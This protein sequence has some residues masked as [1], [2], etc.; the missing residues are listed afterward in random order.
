MHIFVYGTTH[1]C[2]PT[3]TLLT[4]YNRHNR[5]KMI[6]TELKRIRLRYFKV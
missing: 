5:T 1:Y 2:R 6:A 4:A 3:I